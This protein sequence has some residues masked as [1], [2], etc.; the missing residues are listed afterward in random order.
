SINSGWLAPIQS[1]HDAA[2]GENWQDWQFKL[3]LEWAEI[4]LGERLALALRLGWQYEAPELGGRHLIS[5]GLGFQSK[6]F[7]LDAAYWIPIQQNHPLQNTLMFSLGY[8]WNPD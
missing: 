6:R 5:T 8:R 4:A 2:P 1:I 3:G 7:S